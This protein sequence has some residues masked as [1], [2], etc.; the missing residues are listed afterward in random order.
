MIRIRQNP[1]AANKSVWIPTSVASAA[2]CGAKCGPIGAARVREFGAKMING[3]LCEDYQ[4]RVGVLL[5]TSDVFSD[6]SGGFSSCVPPR[7]DAQTHTAIKMSDIDA[8][9]RSTK[10]MAM[11]SE[12]GGGEKCGLG[13]DGASACGAFGGAFGGK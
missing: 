8:R 7:N 9:V 4:G 3:L 12:A 10:T 13:V 5:C 11:S 1:S 6:V 2:T